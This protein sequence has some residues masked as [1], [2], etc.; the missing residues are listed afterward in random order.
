MTGFPATRAAMRRADL[1]TTSWKANFWAGSAVFTLDSS[2]FHRRL[3][4]W[5]RVIR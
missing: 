3:L 1:S 2:P 4:S 5:G